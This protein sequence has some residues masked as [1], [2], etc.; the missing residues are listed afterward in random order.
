LQHFITD[1][2]PHLPVGNDDIYTRVL[3]A[4]TYQVRL[5]WGMKDLGPAC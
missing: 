2:H 3:P 5:A 4:L 1:A